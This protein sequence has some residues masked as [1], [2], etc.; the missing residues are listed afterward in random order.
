M[1]GNPL[2]LVFFGLTVFFLLSMVGLVLLQRRLLE[3]QKRAVYELLADA[4]KLAEEERAD[5][6]DRE[7]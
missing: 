3:Q 4:K 6:S 7:V 2:L 1:N 5:A